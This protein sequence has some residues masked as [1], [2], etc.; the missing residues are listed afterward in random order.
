MI[1]YFRLVS[2]ADTGLEAQSK[3]TGGVEGLHLLR[4]V[5]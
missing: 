2:L 4:A 5:S 3:G 1:Q